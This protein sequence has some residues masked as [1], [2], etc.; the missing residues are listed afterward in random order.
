[1]IFLS[2][3][4]GII[5]LKSGITKSKKIYQFYIAIGEYNLV[6]DKYLIHL[7]TIL[8]SLEITISIGYFLFLNNLIFFSIS[9]ILQL[10]YILILFKNKTKNFEKNCNCF[11]LN[12]PKEISL[13]TIISNIFLFLLI[14][15][16]YSVLI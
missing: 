5:Y 4:L 6:T 15:I 7:T 12:V 1:M 14:I 3:I 16:N 8:V 10:F 9:L 2:I 13:N 11:P